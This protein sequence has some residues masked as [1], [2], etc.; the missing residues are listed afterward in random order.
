VFDVDM[1]VYV[2]CSC[3]QWLSLNCLS[4]SV[5]VVFCGNVLLPNLIFFFIN[6]HYR[7]LLLLG[8]F[9]KKKS[10]GK[11]GGKRPTNCVQLGLRDQGP[12]LIKL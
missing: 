5:S 12:G 7:E 3:C 6:W 2:V 9:P 10:E 8:S 1:V 11:K 4:H